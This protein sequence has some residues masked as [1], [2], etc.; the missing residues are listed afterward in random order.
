MTEEEKILLEQYFPATNMSDAD[1][2]FFLK[3]LFASK[4]LTESDY[5]EGEKAPSCYDFVAMALDNIGP[6]INFD[7][8]ISNGV[9]NKLMYGSIMPNKNRYLIISNLFRISPEVKGIK[10][11]T[12]TDEF[13]FEDDDIVRNSNCNARPVEPVRITLMTDEELIAYYREKIGPIKGLKPQ[14]DV[15][16]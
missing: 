15:Q 4:E 16:E 13:V 3:L 2:A 14:G 7:G 5:N 8:Y 12:V 10:A 9:E 11:Y 1:R 6:M